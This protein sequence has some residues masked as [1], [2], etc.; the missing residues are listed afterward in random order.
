MI[1]HDVLFSL[2]LSLASP[3]SLITAP[4]VI[5]PAMHRFPSNRPQ[6]SVLLPSFPVVPPI[7]AAAAA[8]SLG[9]NPFLPPTRPT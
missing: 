6:S 5:P 4:I 8:A 9:V 7:A 3:K 2:S 1:R